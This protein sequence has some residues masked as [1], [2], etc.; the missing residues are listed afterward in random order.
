MR[1]DV[2]Y[3][4]TEWRLSLAERWHVLAHAPHHPV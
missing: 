1:E 2:M 4:S 3:L